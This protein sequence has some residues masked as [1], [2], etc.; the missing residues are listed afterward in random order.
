MWDIVRAVADIDIEQVT[1]QKRQQI[2]TSTHKYGSDRNTNI[3]FNII[4]ASQIN[5]MQGIFFIFQ[6]L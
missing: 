5:V 6:M 3:I 2:H 1:Q 4:K